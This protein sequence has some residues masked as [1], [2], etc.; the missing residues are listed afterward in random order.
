MKIRN[1]FVSNSSSSSYILAV[2]KDCHCENCKFDL[3]TVF[4]IISQTFKRLEDADRYYPMISNRDYTLEN[5]SDQIEECRKNIEFSN[6][7]L[8]SIKDIENNKDAVKLFCRW[9]EIFVSG[10]SIVQ[11]R[12]VSEYGLIDK[13]IVY[14]REKLEQCIK[15]NESIIEKLEERYDTTSKLKDDYDIYSFTIDYMDPLHK[16]VKGLIQKDFVEVIEQEGY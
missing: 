11:Q 15:E 3:S 8:S 14:V 16:F 10:S 2:K 9:K 5:I 7:E 12:K 6:R 1:G 4:D 13:E